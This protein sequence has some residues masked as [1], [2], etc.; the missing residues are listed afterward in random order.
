ML[1][2]LLSH[3]NVNYNQVFEFLNPIVI[4]FIS[5]FQKWIGFEDVKS[6]PTYFYVQRN[7]TFNQTKTPVPFEIEKV[8]IGGAMNLQTGKFTAPRSGTYFFSLSG[9]AYIP[10]SSSKLVFFMGLYV[11]G[12]QI[13][14]SFADESGNS[15]G[16]W[17]TY[18]L[19]SSL[20][21]RAG[22]L[23]WVEI[24][25][26]STGV[27]LFDDPGHYTHFNGWLLQEHI[28]N[29]LNTL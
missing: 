25:A 14:R 20:S 11:N 5:G 9:I 24:Q 6:S 26:Q 22:D 17:E 13:G 1:V 12:I 19:Q 10:V 23:V 8:N 16:E 27:Y 28:S 29:S 7:S 15:A 21:L 3:L 2:N 4:K 18:S